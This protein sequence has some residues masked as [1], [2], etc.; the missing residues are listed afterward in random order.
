MSRIIH[1]THLLNDQ[2]SCTS[3]RRTFIS[4]LSQKLKH[5]E[6]E[7]RVFNRAPL[8]HTSSGYVP[9]KV[10]KGYKRQSF[11]T[12]PKK[13]Q[14][15]KKKKRRFRVLECILN[16]HFKAVQDCSCLNKIHYLQF[17]YAFQLGSDQRRTHVSADNPKSFKTSDNHD[18]ERFK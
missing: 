3:A 10:T 17:H 16:K 11:V 8:L 6:W 14:Q 1:L 12:L 4:S 7:S 2:Q 15:K 18:A 13:I 5:S 9:M